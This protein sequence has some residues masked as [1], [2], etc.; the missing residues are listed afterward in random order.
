MIPTIIRDIT[1]EHTI[2]IPKE[3]IVRH[4]DDFISIVIP[5]GFNWNH[6]A[7]YFCKDCRAFFNSLGT[8]NYRWILQDE[9][10]IKLIDWN[11]FG[12]EEDHFKNLS[13]FEVSYNFN[14]SKLK[15]RLQA[16][17]KTILEARSILHESAE[18]YEYCSEIARLIDNTN[19]N[20]H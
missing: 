1:N 5:G 16:I 18:E 2:L 7:K 20:Q 12:Q 4:D 6:H 17:D 19:N 3:F 14:G 10:E 8:I 9:H 13:K 15:L 11:S